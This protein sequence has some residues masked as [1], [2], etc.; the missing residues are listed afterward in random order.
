MP[1]MNRP[2]A[3]RLSVTGG[4]QGGW[5]SNL[6]PSGSRERKILFGIVVPVLVIASLLLIFDKIVMPIV[7]RQG[8]AFRLPDFTNQRVLE[9]GLGL[10]DLELKYEISSEQY[11]PGKP[12]GVILQQFPK[13]GT[14]VKPGRMVKFIISLG[15]KMIPV[16]ELTGKSVRQAMLDLETA[17]LV[18]GDIRYA[19]SDTIPERVVVFSYPAATEE[20]PIGS[21]VNLMVNHGRASNFTF[22]PKVV[23][24]MLDEASKRIE[25]KSLQMGIISYR[26]DENYLP[27]TV[28]EQSEPHGAELDIGTEIDLVISSM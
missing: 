6:F 22:M 14:K 5:F 10:S 15:M 1:D 26:T 25:D 21:Q 4:K 12:P 28:L 19:L 8:S 27:E 17:G 24:L 2:R 18:L 3:S 11:A 9:A 23:G 20:I 16:P 13:A 7:T